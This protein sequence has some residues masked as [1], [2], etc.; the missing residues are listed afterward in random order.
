MTYNTWNFNNEP[1]IKA[2]S[3]DDTL[4]DGFTRTTH[5]LNL[6]ALR[7][8]TAGKAMVAPQL[9]QEMVRLENLLSRN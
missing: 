4:I 2:V 9:L 8:Q 6:A 3:Q 7:K 5:E 1:N